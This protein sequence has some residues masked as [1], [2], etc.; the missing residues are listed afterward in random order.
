MDE[1]PSL[2]DE[3]YF[4]YLQSR[5]GD[6]AGE[7][8]AKPLPPQFGS[9]KPPPPRNRSNLTIILCSV[10]VVV[11]LG[12][13]VQGL[14]VRRSGP[15]LESGTLNQLKAEAKDW[16]RSSVQ[17]I[18]MPQ[19]SHRGELDFPASSVELEH[20]NGNRWRA[21][22]EV[23]AT[24]ESGDIEIGEPIVT[25]TQLAKWEMEFEYEGAKKSG[26]IF[27]VLLDGAMIYSK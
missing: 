24:S 22:G 9:K 8:G 10:G 26:E 19:L 7:G 14:L 15:T 20:L 27:K 6:D 17:S 4:K 2:R 23:T 21:T 12:L 25:N 13:I 3:A 11:L 5:V 16:S 1:K 18:I